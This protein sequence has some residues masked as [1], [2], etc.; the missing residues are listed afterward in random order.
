M[1]KVEKWESEWDSDESD[2]E[3]DLAVV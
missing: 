3:A 2:D 1:A